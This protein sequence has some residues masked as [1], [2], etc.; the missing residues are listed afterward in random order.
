MRENWRK[1]D[2]FSNQKF[3]EKLLKHQE[4]SVELMGE[5]RAHDK[6]QNDKDK[7]THANFKVYEFRLTPRRILV[8]LIILY[9][10]FDHFFGEQKFY[11]FFTQNQQQQ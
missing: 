8:D 2:L 11:K 3:H 1:G 6:K 9:F 5:M 4:K 7:K 10:L